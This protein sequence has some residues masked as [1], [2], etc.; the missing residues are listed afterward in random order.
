[1]TINIAII[2]LG[3]IGA[4]IGL[5]L[6]EHP[7]L[8]YRVGH[9]RDFQN[10]QRA[11][12]MGAVDKMTHN[13]LAAVREADLVLLSLPIDQIR[14]TV[15]L[16]AP[17]LKDSAVVMDTGPA[18][19][20]VAAWAGEIL[21]PGRYYVGLTPVLNPEYLHEHATGISA[22]HADLFRRGLIAIVAPPRTPSEAIKLGADLARLLGADPLFF[23]PVEIDSL[24][25]ATH[26]L[27]QL[28]A[29]A[30]LNATV[31]QPG[32]REGRKVAGRAYFETTNPAVLLSEPE[33]I[34]S[35]ALLNREHVLRWLDSLIASLQTL[36]SDLVDQNVGG[37]EGRLQRAR[38]A[39]E[40]WWQQRQAAD[41]Q[42]EESG[43]AAEARLG[44]RE[45]QAKTGSEGFGRLLGL[46]PR[47]KIGR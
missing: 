18:K 36:R 45:L 15:T 13:L 6:A 21:P 12:K 5:A 35:S 31:D 17:E 3:Q 34:S 38:R 44:S 1:M 46:A 9:D 23:D 41:W 25:A 26:I 7:K 2:G 28:V 8:V 22:A 47:R 14:E 42:A 40:T 33:A 29:A 24:M 43:A 20:V 39:R 10:A 32:W 11:E 27:P 19:E 30:L 37:L 16:I 4:S